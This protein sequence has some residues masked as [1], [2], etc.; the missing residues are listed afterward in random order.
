MTEE[1]ATP[2]NGQG[3]EDVLQ[4]SEA[5]QEPVEALP[6]E[7]SVEEL[8]AELEA[9]L[10]AATASKENEL[11]AQAEMQ[12]VRR[13][14]ERDV[15]NAHKFALEKMTGELLTVVDNLER[16]LQAADATDESSK[17]LREGV[18]MTL[19]GFVKTLA[20]FKIEQIDPEGEP[21]DPQLHQ[22]M[23]MIE[24]AEVEPN[25]VVA[26]LQK[27]Y[28]L[29]GRLVRPAMVMVSKAAAAPKIDEQA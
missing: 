10:E 11:R 9:A 26:V 25:T 20:K 17:A 13:R 21:F 7:G 12:N 3:A 16:A 5:V 4:E 22:A 14:A 8:K 27:G 6:E 28:S 2:E 19:D 23:S 1:K 24:N 29:H 18:E 15:E